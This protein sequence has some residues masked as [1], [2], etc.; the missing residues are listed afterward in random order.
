RLADDAALDELLAARVLEHEARQLAIALEHGTADTL[1]LAPAELGAHVVPA[2]RARAAATEEPAA[3]GALQ[4]AAARL[5]HAVLRVVHD[6]D[7]ADV[8]RLV[9]QRRVRVAAVA[10]LEAGDV[11]V[12][13]AE[14]ADVVVRGVGGPRHDVAPGAA[15]GRLAGHDVETVDGAH[16]LVAV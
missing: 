2:L 16:G 10:E 15:G 12:V 7:D 6:G 9:H 5:P 8:L 14:T 11:A 1:L 4:V 3:R 13:E